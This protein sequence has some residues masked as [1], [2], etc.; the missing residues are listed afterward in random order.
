MYR[1]SS[2]FYELGLINNSMW[3]IP[4]PIWAGPLLHPGIGFKTKRQKPKSV[5][6][7]LRNFMH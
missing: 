6:L 1:K 5:S 7:M 2:R 3:Y 4:S